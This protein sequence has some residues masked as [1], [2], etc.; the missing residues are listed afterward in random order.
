MHASGQSFQDIDVGG[1][2]N[3]TFQTRLYLYHQAS[4]LSE[5]LVKRRDLSMCI[6]TTLPVFLLSSCFGAFAFHEYYVHR[7][8]AAETC[9]FLVMAFYHG[10]TLA[11]IIHVYSLGV[12]M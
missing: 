10:F 12:H 11:G 4:P 5:N 6:F 8:M 9:F 7:Q 1:G 2:K 3:G